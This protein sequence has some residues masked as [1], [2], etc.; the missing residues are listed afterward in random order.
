MSFSFLRAVT[1]T[2]VEAGLAG[3][4]ISSPVAGFLPILFLLAGRFAAFILSRPGSVNSPAARFRI[5]RS[6]T[7][8]SSS[9]TEFTC[10][11]VKLVDSAISAKIMFL[12][13]LEL[14]PGFFFGAGALDCFLTAAFFLGGLFFVGM[15]QF[16]L[17]VNWL[18][19][20][21]P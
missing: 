14:I 15:Y 6:I 9:S 5:C 2:L 19:A 4:T 12:V 1:L 17:T 20:R 21:F 18:V 10:T 16:P 7:D 13:I 8:S 3:I 11:L